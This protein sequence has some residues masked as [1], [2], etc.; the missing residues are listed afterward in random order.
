[1]ALS[2]RALAGSDMRPGSWAR[3]KKEREVVESRYYEEIMSLFLQ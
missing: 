1:M 2:S 3:G